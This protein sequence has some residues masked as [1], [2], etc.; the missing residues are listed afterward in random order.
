MDSRVGLKG[1]ALKHQGHLRDT[2]P[3]Q[4]LPSQSVLD[5]HPSSSGRGTRYNWGPAL[6]LS[7]SSP[8][9]CPRSNFLRPLCIGHEAQSEERTP[10]GAGR[11]LLFLQSAMMG[12]PRLPASAPTSLVSR[13]RC[14]SSV[15]ASPT[16]GSRRS[17]SLGHSPK[18]KSLVPG[19]RG[20]AR[21][22]AGDCEELGQNRPGCG[23]CRPGGDSESSMAATEGCLW[24]PVSG[25]SHS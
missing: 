3:L 17:P 2:C 16:Q 24:A 23:L 9:T 13:Q 19:R 4:L 6:L 21:A 11:F 25:G 8:I 18:Q 14:C 22:V 1:S 7:I 12:R 15:H 20:E 10:Q 5:P